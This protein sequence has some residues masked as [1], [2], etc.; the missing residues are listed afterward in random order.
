MGTSVGLMLGRSGLC[1]IKY[2]EIPNLHFKFF[3]LEHLVHIFT[4]E[5]LR[6]ATQFP[7]RKACGGRRSHFL[8]VSFLSWKIWLDS[9]VGMGEIRKVPCECPSREIPILRDRPQHPQSPLCHGRR[10]GGPEGVAEAKLELY[11][12]KISF[13]LL[14]PLVQYWGLFW[15]S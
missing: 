9:S 2:V 15:K 14:H 5:H 3:H 12:G 1:T 11:P 4:N 13:T 8:F 6:K 10:G 7:R